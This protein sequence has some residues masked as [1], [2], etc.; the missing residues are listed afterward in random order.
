M[1]SN[2]SGP[3]TEINCTECG[4]P[5][6]EPINKQEYAT[7]PHCGSDQRPIS[8]CGAKINIKEQSIYTLIDPNQTG[9][10]KIRYERLSGDDLHRKS[11]KWNKKER[12]IDRENDR[13]MEK[14]IDPETGGVIHHCDEP[15]SEH[16]GH[17][18][19]KKI[20]K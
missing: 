5:I 2:K 7:C 19:A 3:E 15:L 16:Q 11:G 9:K 12:I 10:S 1:K 18:S 14:F 4:N 6:E 13:Y 20:T 17:G 8:N